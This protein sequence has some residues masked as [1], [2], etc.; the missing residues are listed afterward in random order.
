M[1]LMNKSWSTFA[2]IAYISG[3]WMQFAGCGSFD[4]RGLFDA[5]GSTT[6]TDAGVRGHGGAP[7]G[8][9]T[10]TTMSAGSASGTT[11]GGGAAGMDG[12]VGTGNSGSR[13]NSGGST[14]SGA[15]TAG[16]AVGGTGGSAGAG[17]GSA[18]GGG[19]GGVCDGLHAMKR[20]AFQGAQACIQAGSMTE[21][22]LVQD[23]C[24][25]DVAVRRAATQA[26]Q[27]Y[28]MSVT[29]LKNNGCLDGCPPKGCLVFS[30]AVCTPGVMSRL[31]C[32]AY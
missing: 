25:C 23:E 2:T 4:E 8:S 10:V 19:A 24:G 30:G 12:G 29:A 21:C 32:V 31:Q 16:S 13:G 28:L 18:G 3:T 17:G 7:G 1:V 22:R 6:G 9:V 15:V 11:G 26:T 5:P 27:R 14:S 20:M